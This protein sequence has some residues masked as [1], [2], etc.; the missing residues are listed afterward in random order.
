M[1]KY[2]YWPI[3][4]HDLKIWPDYFE[5]VVDGSKTFEVR[6]DDRGFVEG[7]TLRLR[8]WSPDTEEYTGRE[9]LRRVGY[10][11]RGDV[12]GLR[13]GYVVMAL[14]NEEATDEAR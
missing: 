12:G 13:D 2:P 10:I 8:E 1:S 14:L 9:V 3:Q 7:D 4:T 5:A 6:L 11:Y